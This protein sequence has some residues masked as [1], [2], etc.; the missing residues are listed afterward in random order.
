M[1]IK[2]WHDNSGHDDYRT[3]TH[4]DLSDLGPGTNLSVGQSQSAGNTINDPITDVGPAPG[5][6]PVNSPPPVSELD[7]PDL[8]VPGTQDFRRPVR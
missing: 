5:S 4:T 8:D 6:V 2:A 3:P 7:D 1:A